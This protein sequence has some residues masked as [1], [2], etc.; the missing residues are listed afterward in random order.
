MAR[1]AL[2][3]SG[4]AVAAVLRL[5]ACG[6]DA[7]GTGADG[8]EPD[9]SLGGFGGSVA[10]GAAAGI[11]AVAGSSGPGGAGGG[12][13]E[14]AIVASGGSP[15]GGS[16]GTAGSAASGGT[17]PTGGTTSTG[18]TAGSSGTGGSAGTGGAAGAAGTA[19]GGGVAGTAGASGSGGVSGTAGT[20]GT[21]GASGT[22][23]AGGDAGVVKP[24]DI[25]DLSVWLLS[26]SGVSTTGSKVTKWA[27]QSGS[28]H[29]FDPVNNPS[30]PDWLPS[31]VNGLPA[32][33]FDGTSS[34]LVGPS[35]INVMTASES[36]I[37]LVYRPVTIVRS[38]P[39]ANLNDGILCD[40]TAYWWLSA[41]SGVGVQ[42]GNFDGTT[43]DLTTFS[44][45]LGQAYVF[46]WRHGAGTLM[47]QQGTSAPVTIASGP[48]QSLGTL[49]LGAGYD[50]AHYGNFDLSEM[51]IYARALTDAELGDVQDYLRTRF[52]L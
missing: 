45:T 27:D 47:G 15:L 48:T 51:V 11:G 2:W 43:D 8:S 19:G 10:T 24:S 22:A 32:V 3:T 37:L 46:A 28:G 18:G 35:T 50:G 16:G 5:A 41:S 17:A 38:A 39:T 25:A 49:E 52:A 14:G 21:S 42:M 23:G 29:D 20:S 33:R 44:V 30:R 13:G 7:Q 40:D 6:L 31:V 4:V 12:G 34:R 9:A 1:A 36:T 26:D